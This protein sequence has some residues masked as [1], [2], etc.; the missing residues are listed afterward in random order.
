[1]CVP[2]STVALT[3]RIFGFVHLDTRKRDEEMQDR[4]F[5]RGTVEASTLQQHALDGVE[6][7]APHQLPNHEHK[8][9]EADA[10]DDDEENDED[11]DE[12]GL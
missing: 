8:V 5:M 2:E 10:Y 12:E 1:M 3:L 11:F 4:Y 9:H 7:R 6:V